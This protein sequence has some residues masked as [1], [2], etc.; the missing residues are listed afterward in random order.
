MKS[1]VGSLAFAVAQAHYG[2]YNYKYQNTGSDATYNPW[3]GVDGTSTDPAI[4]ADKATWYGPT[5][6]YS[7]PRIP[8]VPSQSKETQYAICKIE[9]STV[10]WT[11][12]LAQSP[13][14]AI[15]MKTT[16][17]DAPEATYKLTV[18]TYGVDL[19]D[20]SANL[21]EFWPLQ[22]LDRYGAPNQYQDP[23]RGRFEACTTEDESG[24]CELSQKFLL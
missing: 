7:P 9:Y 6:Q 15:A 22:E 24:E 2:S 3:S 12:Q 17:T 11:I 14:K 20:C 10:T 13:G 4:P 5:M 21:P 23:T 18:G 19:T 16:T 1:V 8:Y